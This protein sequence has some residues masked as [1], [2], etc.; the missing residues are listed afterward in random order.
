MSV[1][2]YMTIC[3]G[4]NNNQII[5]SSVAFTSTEDFLYLHSQISI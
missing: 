5:G 2:V 4:Q 3:V 1:N